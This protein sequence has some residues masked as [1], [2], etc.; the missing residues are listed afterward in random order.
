MRK[1]NKRKG[2]TILETLAYISIL[3][4]IILVLIS[5]LVVLTKSYRQVTV[6]RT[7]ESSAL[8]ALDRITS[9]LRSSESI[10]FVNT[11][12]NSSAGV[13][14]LNARST[15]STLYKARFYVIG[16]VVQMD[17]NGIYEGQLTSSSTRVVSLM[18]R[19]IVTPVSGAVR[20]EITL[21][22]DVNGLT[23]TEN[24]YTTTILKNS[25]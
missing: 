7:L 1:D 25:Y 16:G 2:S 19:H 14:T 21:E 4:M 12:L 22:A 15:S 5:T 17:T 6:N 18:F 13:L 24:F 8:L 10:D 23:K 9:T 3:V 11:T 20:V